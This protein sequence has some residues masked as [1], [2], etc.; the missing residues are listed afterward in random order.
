M[1]YRDRDRL[2]LKPIVEVNPRTT[3]G[4]VALKLQQAVNSAR[5]ALWLV[6]SRREVTRLGLL[7]WLNVLLRWRLRIRPG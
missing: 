4:Q 1:V 5:T 3:M 7:A 2:R 6:I